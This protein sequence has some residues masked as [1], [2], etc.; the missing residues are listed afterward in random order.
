MLLKYL[1]EVVFDNKSNNNNETSKSE[2]T[3]TL[4]TDRRNELL[5]FV[6]SEIERKKQ[7]NSK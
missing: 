4:T 1:K 6:Q 3:G 5:N 7:N 2:E